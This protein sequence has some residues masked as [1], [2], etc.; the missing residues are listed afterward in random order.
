MGEA[1]KASPDPETTLERLP[2]GVLTLDAVGR[3]TSA[4]AAASELLGHA[5]G[6]VGLA[7]ADRLFR[8]AEPLGEGLAAALRE[9]LPLH[10]VA[11]PY[12]PPS[13]GAHR[14]LDLSVT[15]LGG[16]G[17]AGGAVVVVTDVT[18]RAEEL[19]RAR[20]FYQ[21]FLH[22]HEAMEVTD[23]EGTLVDV[24]PAFE[25]IY[26]FSRAEV[27][28]QKPR[29]VRSPKTPGSVYASLW[30]NLLDPKVGRWTGELVNLDRTGR[31]HPVRLTI[32]A[33]R[34]EGGEITHF[35]GVASDLSELKA[36]ELQVVRADRLAS[37]G[38]LAAG[39][40]HELNTPLANIMLIAE[41][42]HRRAPNPWV[43]G[44]A[45]AITQQVEAAARIVSGLLDFSRHHPPRQADV[46]LSA[47]A[48]EAIA[49]ARG[50]QSQEVEIDEAHSVQPLWVWGD[51]VQIL[52]V[53]VNV[54][55][56]AF[57]AMEGRGRLT[58]RSGVS[59]RT[60]WVSLAD[61]GS[62]IPPSV[63]PHIFEPFFTTKGDGKGTGLGLSIVHGI[64]QAH[65]GA[66][67]VESTVGVG[68]T[69]RILL[70]HHVPGDRAQL[71]P[72]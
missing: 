52:Q 54:I 55:N 46:D 62:G 5:P 1:A 22:S 67:E 44:R 23:R 24:N 31:E 58:V 49:F 53:L 17:R 34:G 4:N 11:V 61:T 28:G 14:V 39:V 16:A 43:S 66:V 70:P 37:V 64:V 40:A 3:I 18:E 29:I 72:A 63:L 12:A 27:V 20:L 25:R 57:D 47:V 19:A 51:R 36:F 35:I 60:A 59:D 9:G 2:V 71:P 50:K 48:H 38:Q 15:P 7:L 42:L 10:L 45:D 13:S 41:S 56:N 30:N 33:I 68:T 21:S 69:F 6:L 8:E 65:G 32:S 26:G